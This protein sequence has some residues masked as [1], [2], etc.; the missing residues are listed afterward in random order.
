[1][2]KKKKKTAAGI[3]KCGAPNTMP[4]ALFEEKML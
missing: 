2:R 1:M 4:I 3:T